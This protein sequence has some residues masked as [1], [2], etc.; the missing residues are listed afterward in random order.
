[1]HDGFD[2]LMKN[3]DPV[4]TMLLRKT[5][6]FVTFANETII[7][8]FDIYFNLSISLHLSVIDVCK[9]IFTMQCCAV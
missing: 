6:S 4:T 8:E 1:M 2:G 5:P 9:Y 7:L 3:A